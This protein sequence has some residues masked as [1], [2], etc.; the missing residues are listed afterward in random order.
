MAK[1]VK[2]RPERVGTK[3][4]RKPVKVEAHKRS[5]PKPIKKKCR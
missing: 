5:A 4:G 2:C 3:P 1:K